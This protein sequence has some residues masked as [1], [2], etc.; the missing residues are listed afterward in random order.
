MRA[1]AQYIAPLAIASVMLTGCQPEPDTGIHAN[2]V[3]PVHLHVVSG[4][5]DHQIRRFPAVVE[6]TQTAELAFRVGGELQQLPLRP[7]QS[8][9]QGQV[10]AALDPN[11]FELAAEQA[12]A[13]AEL[14]RAQFERNQRMLDQALISAS[15]FDQ[16]QADLRVAEANL[17]SAQANLDYT[18]LKAPFNGVIAHLHVENFENVAPQQPIMTLQ[19][20]GHIDVSIQVPELL[21]ARV[22]RD[23]EYQPDIAFDSV[24]GQT[25]K[26]SIREWDR[27]ADPATNTYRVVF[28]LPSP[29]GVNILPGMTATVLIDATQMTE[30]QRAVM[31]LPVNAVFA[32]EQQPLQPGIAYVWVFEDASDNRSGER[33]GYVR[34]RAVEIADMTNQGVQ[35][36]SGIEPGERVV[37]AGVHQLQEGQKVSAWARERGL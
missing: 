28:T 31:L 32:P 14:T 20:D 30:R 12:Q 18:R 5:S 27:I 22:R 8:V 36:L 10:V 1:I 25:F 24:P 19:V 3:R 7:G 26:A 16:A 11:D 9:R 6:A 13:R 4:D 21:F 17:R 35:V 29:Q 2:H 34:L 37:Q 23:L 15:V 33:Y